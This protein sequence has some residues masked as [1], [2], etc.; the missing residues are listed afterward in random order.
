MSFPFSCT[1]VLG[2]GMG[3]QRQPSV[4][5]A[6]L[7]PVS[8]VFLPEL[9]HYL[10]LKTPYFPVGLDWVSFS[11][12]PAF[13]GLLSLPMLPKVDCSSLYLQSC[14]GLRGCR[15]RIHLILHLSIFL[16]TSSKIMNSR[17]FP[18]YFLQFYAHSVTSLFSV[19][20]RIL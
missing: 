20:N 18:K 14:C 5:S 6:L 12:S 9:P 1:G 3:W 17:S 16:Y 2:S 10:G 19:K 4:G 15:S 11:I 7:P 8:E 13:G